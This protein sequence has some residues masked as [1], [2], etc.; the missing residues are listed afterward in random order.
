MKISEQT[1][2]DLSFFSERDRAKTVAVCR[3]QPSSAGQ[4]CIQS[5]YQLVITTVVKKE[6]KARLEAEKISFAQLYSGK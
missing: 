2:V 4:T 3:S 1:Q 6:Q 5:A